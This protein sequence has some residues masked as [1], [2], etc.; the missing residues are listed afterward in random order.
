M[1]NSNIQALTLA[2]SRPS[3]FK[4]GEV[5]RYLSLLENILQQFQS[6]TG[7]SQTQVKGIPDVYGVMSPAISIL[8]GDDH[9]EV[10]ASGAHTTSGNEF[11]RCTAA[12]V[13][14][15][16]ATPDDNESVFIQV[17]GGH[18]IVEIAGNINGSSSSFIYANGDCVNIVYLVEFNQ[19]VIQ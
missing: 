7:T 19:W 17:Y 4:G 9:A 11:V 3:A 18:F 5:D 6:Q 12:T 10:L 15:L 13:V 14:T 1:A 2:R 8:N 16:N